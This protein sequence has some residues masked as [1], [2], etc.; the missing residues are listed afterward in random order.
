MLRYL[1]Q[2]K[3][4]PLSTLVSRWRTLVDDP[5]RPHIKEITY[6]PNQ[7]ITIPKLNIVKTR[8]NAIAEDLANKTFP[9]S[10]PVSIQKRKS[11]AQEVIRNNQQ[12]Y[13]L[14]LRNLGLDRK[15]GVVVS[16][17][18]PI[19]QQAALQGRLQNL[20][21]GDVSLGRIAKEAPEGRKLIRN[22]EPDDRGLVAMTGMHE[23]FEYGSRK[24]QATKNMF[25]SHIAPR[26][27]TAE[28]NLLARLTP[29]ELFDARSVQNAKETFLGMRSARPGIDLATQL[30]IKNVSEK[31][32]M[33]DA[34]RSVTGGRLNY[35]FG[36]THLPKAVRKRVENYLISQYGGPLG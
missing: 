34:V 12:E 30:G 36:E 28:S 19:L 27:L 26:V 3:S 33:E 4:A 17:K 32:V 16:D 1:L 11:L 15:G 21:A 10:D 7:A 24:H 29:D 23:L 2:K 8:V 9:G 14:A 13:K 6:F 18:L 25:F 22:T 31:K 20:R 35:T 5:M